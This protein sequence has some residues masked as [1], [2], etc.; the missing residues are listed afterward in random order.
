[1]LGSKIGHCW[2]SHCTIELTKCRLA[3]DRTNPQFSDR[4]YSMVWMDLLNPK[5]PDNPGNPVQINVHTRTI[6]FRYRYL[7]GGTSEAVAAVISASPKG[8]KLE[9]IN[10]GMMAVL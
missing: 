7:C 2:V 6:C 4:I 5:N 8:F 9:T 1:M 3:V 10:L